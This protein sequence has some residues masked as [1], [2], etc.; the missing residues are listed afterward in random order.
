MK[1]SMGILTSRFLATAASML[2]AAAVQAEGGGRN[3]VGLG[4]GVVPV[5]QGSSEYRTPPVPMLNYESGSF[6]VT[7]AP[8]CRP[9]D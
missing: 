6:F 5:Y 3:V 9:W 4:V 2:A 8:A 1:T 7:R